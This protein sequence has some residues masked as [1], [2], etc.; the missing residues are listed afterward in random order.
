MTA[1]KNGV[2]TM[3]CSESDDT[4]LY[5]GSGDGTVTQFSGTDCHWKAQRSARVKGKAMS[6]SVC[7]DE[8]KLLVG[9][10]L[11]TMYEIDLDTF[12]PTIISSSHVDGINAVMF[13]KSVSSTA[14][15]SNEHCCTA[16][17][18]G[19]IQMWDLSSYESIL[20]VQEASEATCLCLVHREDKMLIFSGW[21]DC[22]IRVY[23]AS[24]GDTVFYIPN[25][26]RKAV[27]SIDV[28]DKYFISGGEDGI[29][30]VWSWSRELLC[31]FSEHRS[32]PV[33]SVRVDV[34]LPYILHS[35]AEDGQV[36]SYD[37][38][39]E[40]RVKSQFQKRKS[41][42]AMTQRKDSEN[43]LLVVTKC[44]KIQAW[45][46]DYDNPVMNVE[47]TQSSLNAT[48]LSSSGRFLAI[49]GDDGLVKI[50]EFVHKSESP[51]LIA[52]GDG[53]FTRVVDVSWAPD[54]KQLV[55]VAD[56]CSMC[57][58]NFFG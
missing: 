36:L 26:H 21:R 28:T 45:D 35:C 13:A 14:K 32:K 30:N 49:A 40:R 4:C 58:W 7:A 22:S 18:D 38:R 8:T 43:E 46:R 53:H 37:L 6:L 51:V 19:T 17:N 56:N 29:V 5:I 41:Y 16:S 24:S 50:Y 33:R 2:R 54:E 15:T 44:G 47:D 27:S 34:K 55:S 48:S 57:V 52:I 12:T 11:G 39:K 25:A 9:T 42:N 23:D 20:R 3:C 31:Q 10:S 1:A